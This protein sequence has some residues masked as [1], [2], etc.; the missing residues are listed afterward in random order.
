MRNQDL[1]T[2]KRRQLATDAFARMVLK[3]KLTK[4][5]K[6]WLVSIAALLN[7]DDGA[8]DLQD[9]LMRLACS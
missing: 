8:S 4:A 5:D 2:E 3:K 6:Y 7:G 9:R 1:G